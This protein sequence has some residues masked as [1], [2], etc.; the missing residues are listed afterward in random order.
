MSW[1]KKYYEN[2]IAGLPNALVIGRRQQNTNVEQ[3]YQLV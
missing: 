1:S 2:G 3:L